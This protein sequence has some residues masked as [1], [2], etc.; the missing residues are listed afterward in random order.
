MLVNGSGRMNAS[1]PPSRLPSPLSPG[2][3]LLP[4]PLLLAHRAWYVLR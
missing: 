4:P 3:E 2:L 1:L